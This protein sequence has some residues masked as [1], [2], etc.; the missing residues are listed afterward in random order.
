MLK[1]THNSPEPGELVSTETLYRA[2][3]EVVELPLIEENPLE[4]ALKAFLV[5]DNFWPDDDG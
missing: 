5:G 4:I 2:N 3:G 1:Q